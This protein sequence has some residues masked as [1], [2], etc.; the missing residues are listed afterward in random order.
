MTYRN[1]CMLTAALAGIYALS[2]TVAPLFTA[3]I[4]MPE[5]G[6]DTALMGRYFG[7]S[8]WFMAIVCWLLKDCAVA[9]VRHALAIAAIVASVLG[10][11]TSL[12]STVSGQ[13]SAMGWGPVLI[14]LVLLIGWVVV[15]RVASS[16]AEA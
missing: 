11:A 1:M 13:M 9:Q 14:Y 6:A 15:W 16:S 10:L 8:L 12:V 4:Y 5:S 7:I 2:Y 3:S